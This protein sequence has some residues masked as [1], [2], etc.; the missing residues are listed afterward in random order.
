MI[1]NA[2][3]P[4]DECL[5]LLTLCDLSRFMVP[6]DES[7]TVRITDL[8]GE[9]KKKRLHTEV[10]TIDKIACVPVSSDYPRQSRSIVFTHE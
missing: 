10:A 5:I 2:T 6:A 3:R 1:Q 4:R 9:E 7:N 8:K